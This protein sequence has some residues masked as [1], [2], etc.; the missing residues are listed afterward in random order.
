[1]VLML[2][3][4]SD[5]ITSLS[6]QLAGFIKGME[7]KDA[8][9]TSG[10]IVTMMCDQDLFDMEKRDFI[11]EDEESGEEFL[12]QSWYIDNPWELSEATSKHIKRAMYLPPMLV[13]PRK[14][15]NNKSTGYLTKDPESLILG[16]GNHHNGDICL[17]SLNRFNSVALSLNVEML[18][19]I[20]EDMLVD[21][22]MQAKINSDPKRKEQ[23]EKLIADSYHVYAYL[24]K[25]GNR[26]YL[27]HKN[28]KRGR[29]YSQGYH[30]STQGNSFRKSII[31][32]ADK[33]VVEWNMNPS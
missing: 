13:K 29:T 8:V 19:D 22:E 17:D 31:E 9:I 28:D 23:H 18:K 11:F 20:T 4:R 32:L 7:P 26:F 27:E 6:G 5:L 12:T 3:D 30:C 24:V 14:L 16:K 15:T 2:D 33:E 10:E 21:S 25:N 1:M